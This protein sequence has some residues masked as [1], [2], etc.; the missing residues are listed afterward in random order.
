M[1]TQE[2]TLGGQVLSVWNGT[3]FADS[4]HAHLGALRPMFNCTSSAPPTR[5]DDEVQLPSVCRRGSLYFISA[6]G[7]RTA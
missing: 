4:G 3:P 5:A 7:K 2:P 6:S 1:L